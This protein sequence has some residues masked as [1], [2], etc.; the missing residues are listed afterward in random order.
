MIICRLR[1][2]LRGLTGGDVLEDEDAGEGEAG[3]QRR[4][5]VRLNPKELG[6]FATL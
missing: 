1:H 4:L 2:I 6:Q 5:L 3:P